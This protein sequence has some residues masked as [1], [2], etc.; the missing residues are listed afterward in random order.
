MWLA[1]ALK[2]TNMCEND[3]TLGIPKSS[4]GPLSLD[5][6]EVVSQTTAPP[7]YS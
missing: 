1:Y 3:V 7:R 4:Y 6:S 5:L 2:A